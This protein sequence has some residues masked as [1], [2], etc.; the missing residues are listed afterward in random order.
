[1]DGVASSW[2][3]C[4]IVQSTVNQGISFESL[5]S[6]GFIRTK[7]H[8]TYLIT[9]L[10]KVP[11]YLTAYYVPTSFSSPA[12]HKGQATLSHQFFQ[13]SEHKPRSYI[14]TL[15]DTWWWPK[16]SGKH[17]HSYQ[18]GYSRSLEVSSQVPR[19]KLR[20]LILQSG[21]QISYYIVWN[22]IVKFLTTY[23]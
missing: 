11:M 2:L 13:R 15:V 12:P 23:S 4:G 20:C 17:R 3:Q 16:P 10:P 19:A 14:T 7:S 9:Y 5:V 6:R 22:Y 21:G 18:T 8:T 1:M